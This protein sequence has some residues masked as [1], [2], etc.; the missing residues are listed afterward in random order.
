MDICIYD[1]KTLN[2]P[3]GAL[4]Y[5]ADFLMRTGA[6]FE[7]IVAALDDLRSRSVFEFTLESLNYIIRN[8]KLSAPA[9]FVA[10]LFDV[11]PIM[12]IAQDG[13]IIPV[14]KIRKFERAVR[15][16]ANRVAS[17][18]DSNNKYL[19][20]ADGGI[21]EITNYCAELV[22]DELKLDYMPIIPVSCISLANHGPQGIAL[23]AFYGKL[24]RIVRE[25]PPYKIL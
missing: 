19:Y 24:P 2:L 13:F 23:G 5:E 11:K 8:K 7:E 20:L 9:G 17:Q 15:E 22:K 16:I 1:T 4:A 10:T 18:I 21:P 25:L 3:E 12:Q 14:D 6:P